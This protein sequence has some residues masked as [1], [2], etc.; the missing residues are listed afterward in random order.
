MKDCYILFAGVYGRKYE[1]ERV[2]IYE[3][4]VHCVSKQA[5][6][7]ECTLMSSAGTYIHTERKNFNVRPT[8]SLSLS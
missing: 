5:N 4:V 8:I 6:V 2:N 3:T 1:N 7:L